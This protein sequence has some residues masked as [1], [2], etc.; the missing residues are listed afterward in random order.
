M[1]VTLLPA[2]ISI[3]TSG[4][5]GSALTESH[6]RHYTISAHGGCRIKRAPSRSFRSNYVWK[7][8]LYALVHEH[9]LRTSERKQAPS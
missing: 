1:A 5:G 8:S 7:K 3:P 2:L 6:I 4:D 9:A